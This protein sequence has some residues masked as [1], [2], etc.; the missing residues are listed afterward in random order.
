MSTVEHMDTTPRSLLQGKTVA[1]A[2]IDPASWH[3]PINAL[4]STHTFNE[5]PLESR[6][7]G[8]DG[9][10]YF[11]LPTGPDP[12]ILQFYQVHPSL[13]S[14]PPVSTHQQLTRLQ[15][16]LEQSQRRK[17]QLQLQLIHQNQWLQQLQQ[18]Q[19][20]QQRQ[21]PF[22]YLQQ[23]QQHP[24]RLFT[25]QNTPPF[26]EL[27]L[28]N[29][30]PLTSTTQT[31]ASELPYPLGSQT[32][33]CQSTHNERLNTN[34]PLTSDLAPSPLRGHLP[35]P[36]SNL[37]QSQPPHVPLVTQNS[38]PATTDCDTQEKERQ[39]RGVACNKTEGRR[40]LKRLTYEQSRDIIT[41]REGEDP[42]SFQTIAKAMGCSKSTVWRHKQKHLRQ[43]KPMQKEDSQ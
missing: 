32:L 42:E 30:G 14:S 38:S 27:L 25:P 28:V 24:E 9:T 37:E 33:L 13:Q 7:T 21:Q 40:P 8:P 35:L 17:E 26:Q 29:K 31:C 1:P 43:T 10:P 19:Q 34:V 12:L 3:C 39:D 16:L 15:W 2:S 18:Q 4:G 36:V 20:Q 11:S 22:A 41:R 5:T 23:Q 6:A